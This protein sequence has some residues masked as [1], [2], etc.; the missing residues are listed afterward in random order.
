[1]PACATSEIQIT[2][3]P[4][5]END[6]QQTTNFS[7]LADDE[8]HVWTGSAKV[9]DA[10]LARMQRVL[11][12]EELQKAARFRFAKDRNRFL[13]SR[14]TL[15][16]L[17]G[18]YVGRDPSKIDFEFSEKGKPELA[19]GTGQGM[20]FNVAHS[21]DVIV[22]AFARERHLGVDVE[23]IR[24]DFGVS[25]IAERFFSVTE[26]KSLRAL[27]IAQQHEAFFRCW[28]RKEAYVKATG[29]GLSLPLD[30]FDVTFAPGQPALLL[31]T[32]PDHSECDR[33][34]MRSLDLKPHYAAAL[35]IERSKSCER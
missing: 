11:S 6:P 15:R 19:P 5:L 4:L 12:Q 26:R 7:T 33:W 34:L 28:T 21:G 30:Q 10:T 16:T 22:W 13:V 18:G 35:V 31:D 25:E 23:N 2:V 24:F 20:R 1:M 3:L 27:P 32:R 29:D 8:V 14:G 9:E 17:L